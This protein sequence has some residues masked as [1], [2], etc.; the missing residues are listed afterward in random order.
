MTRRCMPR[1]VF[2]GKTYCARYKIISGLI[3]Y[4][5]VFVFRSDGQNHEAYVH[6]SEPANISKV[7]GCVQLRRFIDQQKLHFET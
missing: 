7:E 5:A 3:V 4:H 6:F 1:K 2:Y